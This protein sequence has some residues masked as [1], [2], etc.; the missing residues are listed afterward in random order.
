MMQI[1][2][3]SEAVNR[4]L[5]F[6]MSVA[7]NRFKGIKYKHVYFCKDN[8]RYY[9]RYPN[10]CSD[11]LKIKTESISDFISK[12][13]IVEIMRWIIDNKIA[14]PIHIH[15][16]ISR[17]FIFECGLINIL[18]NYVTVVLWKTCSEDILREL[19]KLKSAPFKIEF[20]IGLEEYLNAVIGR[21]K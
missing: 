6:Y 20:I 14:I 3:L 12:K 11:L 9:Y 5:D 17:Q 19:E 4:S 1:I 21:I 2:P 7:L 15:D 18:Q 16:P 8:G 13:E 10:K